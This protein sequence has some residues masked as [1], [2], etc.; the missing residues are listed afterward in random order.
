MILSWKKKNLKNLFASSLLTAVIFDCL[1]KKSHKA[2]HCPG[3]LRD[4]CV[5][6]LHPRSS[7]SV[8]HERHVLTFGL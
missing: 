5:Y 3:M 1:F 7:A 4:G 6:K 8:V 2:L